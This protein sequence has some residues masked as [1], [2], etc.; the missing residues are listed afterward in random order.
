MD[1]RPADTHI[2]QEK[3][4][5][6]HRSGCDVIQ[7]RL[8]N[9][10]SR[11]ESYGPTTA[12]GICSEGERTRHGR[13]AERGYPTTE[14][15]VWRHGRRT[16]NRQTVNAPSDAHGNTFWTVKDSA[17]SARRP[18]DTRR[19]NWSRNL[20]ADSNAA[21]AAAGIHTGTNRLKRRQLSTSTRKVTA[22]TAP[23]KTQQSTL[24]AGQLQDPGHHTLLP[25]PAGTRQGIL[26]SPI[27]TGNRLLHV[28]TLD[29]LFRRL[30]TRFPSTHPAA[31]RASKTQR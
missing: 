3:G 11:W 28:T 23:P 25:V 30:D 31:S 8:L 17:C 18:P 27:V 4:T 6:G 10:F 7:G 26:G 20:E 1:T 5:L 13:Y 22:S 12:T 14:G 2:R 16:A 24:Y 21:V 9:E 29:P 19:T 15:D